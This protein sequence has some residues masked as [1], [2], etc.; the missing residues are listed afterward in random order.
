[1]TTGGVSRVTT[2]KVIATGLLF[3]LGA[4][5]AAARYSGGG[6][7][8]ERVLARLLL[9]AEATES[10]VYR[11]RWRA[12][13]AEP[14]AEFILDIAYKA[15]GKFRLVATGPFGSPAFTAVVV[16]E[17]FW[18]VDHQQGRYI[19]DRIANLGDYD[20]PMAQ[21]FSGP[22]RDLFSGGWGGGKTVGE[23]MPGDRPGEYVGEGL[24]TRWEIQWDAGHAAPRSIRA[25]DPSDHG[26]VLAEISF[27]RSR[28]EYPFWQMKRLRLRAGESGGEHRWDLLRQEYNGKTPDHFFDP[29]PPPGR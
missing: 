9:R 2:R 28:D 20:V 3:F 18:F 22:W 26:M 6:F 8:G 13:G 14:H 16:G 4:G 21:F 7:T 5:C 29:L 11:V 15:P 17:D 24:Y 1:M 19:T 27:E 12:I 25:V 10:A 23:L